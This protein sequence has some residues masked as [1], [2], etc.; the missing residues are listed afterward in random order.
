MIKLFALSLTLFLPCQSWSAMSFAGTTTATRISRANAFD[1]TIA[2]D[3][4]HTITFWIY[5][6]S[7][8]NSPVIYSHGDDSIN[9][10]GEFNTSVGFYWGCEGTFR[11]YTGWGLEANR[12]Y[13]IALV[14]TASGDSGNAY[15]DGNLMST[16]TGAIGSTPGTGSK[17]IYLGDYNTSGF[18]VDGIIDDFRIYNYSLSAAEVQNLASSR[19]RIHVDALPILWWKLDQGSDGVT[20]SGATILDST[21]NGFTGTATNNPTWSASQWISY[22]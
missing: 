11:T 14:K 18:T 7:F 10:F 13:H 12:W 22:P 16:Y 21:G 9:F 6:R 15:L 20:A 4:T 3:N 17:A 1:D 2:G 19:S 8:A 5:M